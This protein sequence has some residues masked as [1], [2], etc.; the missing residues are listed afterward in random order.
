MTYPYVSHARCPEH[1]AARVDRLFEYECGC[2]CAI[3]DQLLPGDPVSARMA[4]A[5][6]GPGLP[7]LY[8]WFKNYTY[9]HSEP[10][11]LV[12][13]IIKGGPFDGVPVRFHARD[14]QLEER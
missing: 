10:G 7:P 5:A 9:S 3:A 11:Q 12:I 14:V 13:V 1:R 2:P 4:Y 6:Q 8:A